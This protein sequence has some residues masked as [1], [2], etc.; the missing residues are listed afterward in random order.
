MLIVFFL[1]LVLNNVLVSY[2]TKRKREYRSH[3]L[4]YQIICRECNYSLYSIICFTKCIL[5]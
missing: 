2:P 3:S 1:L 5:F 4:L